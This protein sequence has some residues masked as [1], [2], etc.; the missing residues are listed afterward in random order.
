M[1]CLWW[2]ITISDV[3]RYQ[4][5]N[6][7]KRRHFKNPL[8][9]RFYKKIQQFYD[10]LSGI[11]RE[12]VFIPDYHFQVIMKSPF[13][14]LQQQIR[15]NGGLDAFKIPLKAGFFMKFSYY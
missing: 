1:S 6:E 3:F 15:Q 2:Y 8:R 9:D 4:F 14:F 13:K 5:N 10:K 12:V 11:A 7:L